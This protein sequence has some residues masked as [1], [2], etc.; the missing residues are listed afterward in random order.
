MRDHILININGTTHRIEGDASFRTLANYLR[1]DVAAT[2][3]K[4]VCE[5]GDCGAC[6]VLTRRT[7]DTDY[8]PVNSCILNLAQLDGSSIVTVEGLSRGGGG[9]ARG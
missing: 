2:G 5:E 3:T 1:Q 6:T 4:I 7:A 9:A 8:R